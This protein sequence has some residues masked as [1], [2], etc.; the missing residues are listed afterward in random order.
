MSTGITIKEAEKRIDEVN[1]PAIIKQKVNESNKNMTKLS[2]LLG[3]ELSYMAQQLERK[4]VNVPLLYA[5]SNH[6]N[7][8]LFEPFLNL[9]PEDVRVTQKEKELQQQIADLQKQLD[10]TK[11]ERDLLKEILMK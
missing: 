1:L 9:L 7:V 10:D 4:N 8:N 3:R 2:K 6:L 5:L 11:R